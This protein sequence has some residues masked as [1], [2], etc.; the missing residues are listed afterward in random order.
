MYI[1][2]S[3]YYFDNYEYPYIFKATFK[4]G[5]KFKFLNV[6]YEYYYSPKENEQSLVCS[7][8]TDID[9]TI[10]AKKN[11]TIANNVLQYL[12]NIPI[13]NEYTY[14]CEVSSYE[15]ITH[16]FKNL[17]KE[18]K[19][20]INFISNKVSKFNKEKILFNEVLTL[21]DIAFKNHIADRYEDAILYYFKIL[22]K[23]A[24][25]NYIKYHE[26]NYTNAVKNNNK[27]CLHKFLETF[28]KE[29][30]KITMTSDMLK[31]TVD[32][33][34]NK[35]RY[36]SYNSIFLKISFFCECKN[37]QFD[38]KKLHLLVKNRNKLAHGDSIDESTIMTSLATAQYLA[39]NFISIYFF[40]KSYEDISIFTDI[41]DKEGV[42]IISE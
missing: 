36:E 8:L 22:E 17:S 42:H 38:S 7:Y 5:A 6:Y 28:L 12:L 2:T 35:I 30:L 33:V 10:I 1:F 29:N 21:N 13:I 31:T 14:R 9:D 39:Q 15:T 16:T 26:R 11:I 23:L 27:K 37:I 20:K 19:E 41:F 32:E 18:K 4:N 24:K 40:R 25:K 3:K 34:Y